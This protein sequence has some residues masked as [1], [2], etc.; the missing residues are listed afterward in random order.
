M[1]SSRSAV[2]VPATEQPARLLDIGSLLSQLQ[3]L[4]DSRGKKG[5]RYALPIILLFIILDPRQ[6]GWGR[7]TEWD[8]GLGGPSQE[9]SY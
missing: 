4:T 5:L 8:S 9:G 6:A 3:T 7:P 2:S 1:E